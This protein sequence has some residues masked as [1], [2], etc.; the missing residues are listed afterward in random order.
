MA[1][2]VFVF[3]CLG[4][5]FRCALLCLG[6]LFWCFVFDL[7]IYLLIVMLVLIVALP[8]VCFG[9]GFGLSGGFCWFLFM[10][11]TVC[12][13]VVDIWLWVWLDV[14]LLTLHT[15]CWF[16]VGYWL[17]LFGGFVWLIGAGCLLDDAFF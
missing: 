4:L 14:G 2:V 13:L 7:F 10:G 9:L 6:C 3:V 16:W 15:F 11:D 8:C 12:W 5:G 1:D 17:L